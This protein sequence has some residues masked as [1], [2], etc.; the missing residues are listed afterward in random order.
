[1]EL[2]IV[3]DYPFKKRGESAESRIFNTFNQF[4]F[5]SSINYAKKIKR[6][7]IRSPYNNLLII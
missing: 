1:M 5:L 4:L 7:F 3:C 6:I 2:Y